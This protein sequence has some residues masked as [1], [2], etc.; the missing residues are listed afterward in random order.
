MEYW[1]QWLDF[2]QITKLSDLQPSF[3]MV[4]YAFLSISIKA[5]QIEKVEFACNNYDSYPSLN[6]QSCIKGLLVVRDFCFWAVWAAGPVHKKKVGGR[7]WATFEGGFFMFS[8]SKFFIFFLKTL[9]SALKSCIRFF[10]F[11]LPKTWKKHP[12]KLLIIGPN[13]FFSVLAQLPKR[14]KNRNPVPPKAP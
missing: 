13:F 4:Q 2:T 8:G 10:I 6:T 12:Q 11:L 9:S 1:I 5:A 7:L 3:Q 14:P